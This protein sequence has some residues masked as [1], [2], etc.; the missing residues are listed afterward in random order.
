MDFILN[1]VNERLATGALDMTYSS[2]SDPV[3]ASQETWG[4][5]LSPEAK[6]VLLLGSGELGR[7]VALEAMRLGVEVCSKHA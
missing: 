2:S 3:D 7:E 5:P 1:V 4:A 6:R